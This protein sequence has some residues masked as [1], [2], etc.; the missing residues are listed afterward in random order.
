MKIRIA[1]SDDE[2]SVALKAITALLDN[3]PGVRVHKTE[4]KPPYYIVFLTTKRLQKP[5]KA[6]KNA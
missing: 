3:L 2:E 4:P 1:W 6:E 5:R